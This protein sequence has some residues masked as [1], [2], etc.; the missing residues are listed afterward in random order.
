MA[1]DGAQ[2]NEVAYWLEK[3]H[4]E[5]RLL[6]MSGLQL[7]AP[8]ERRVQRKVL[9][10]DRQ[11]AIEIMLA[12]LAAAEDGLWVHDL[13]QAVERAGLK[14]EAAAIRARRKSSLSIA[15]ES[16]AIIK[17]RVDRQDKLPTSKFIHRYFTREHY[18]R[19]H[20]ALPDEV[21]KLLLDEAIDNKLPKGNEES[22]G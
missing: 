3:L 19:W 7:K 21:Q 5:I 2:I 16:G 18:L 8:K 1:Q 10:D 4:A 17:G 9:T 11:K 14:A 22:G 12:R 6:R 15:V 20:A 13:T